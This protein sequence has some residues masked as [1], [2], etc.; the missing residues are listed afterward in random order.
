M[1]R[2]RLTVKSELET[3]LERAIDTLN[4]LCKAIA[5]NDDHQ[6]RDLMLVYN[7]Q[8]QELRLAQDQTAVP[9]DLLKMA[10]DAVNPH[11]YT[12]DTMLQH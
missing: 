1:S 3:K 11:Q 2:L 9:V 7:Q 6:A 5:T 12:L 8:L 4:K 10:D